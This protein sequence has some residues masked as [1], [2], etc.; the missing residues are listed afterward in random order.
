MEKIDRLNVLLELERQG[1]TRQEM[2]DKLNVKRN[3]V[4][5]VLGRYHSSVK[6]QRPKR[7]SKAKMIPPKGIKYVP[8]MHPPTATQKTI[9]Q[10]KSTDCRF[11]LDNGMYCGDKIHE[12]SFCL[13]HFK[14]CYQPNPKKDKNA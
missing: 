4:C 11:I 3:V 2:A 12:R 10:L 14:A 13:S 6:T 7:E 5:G 1:L 9:L 8:L